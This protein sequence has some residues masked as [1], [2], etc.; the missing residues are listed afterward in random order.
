MIDSE[1]KWTTNS[2]SSLSFVSYVHVTLLGFYHASLQNSC[3]QWM[4]HTAPNHARDLSALKCMTDDP[5]NVSAPVMDN[6]PFA[7]LP[8][9]YY[10]VVGTSSSTE[11]KIRGLVLAIFLRHV[12]QSHDK[13]PRNACSWAKSPRRKKKDAGAAAQWFRQE[14]SWWGVTSR[15]VWCYSRP[16]AAALLACPSSGLQLCLTYQTS[17]LNVDFS[18]DWWLVLRLLLVHKILATRGPSQILVAS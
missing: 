7:L 5:L 14:E 15:L 4:A 17:R 11:K 10:P 8:Q 1:T 12:V 9:G 3:W 2:I 6:P 13:Q 16:Q 18:L